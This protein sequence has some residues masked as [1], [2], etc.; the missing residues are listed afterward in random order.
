MVRGPGSCVPQPISRRYGPANVDRILRGEKVAD[1]PV[2]QSTKVEIVI[3]LKTAKTLG[4]DVPAAFL[5]R[6]NEVIE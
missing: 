2:Q 3:N 4:I 6:A 1:L 5:A